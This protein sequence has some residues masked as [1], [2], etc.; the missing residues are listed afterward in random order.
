MPVTLSLNC[1]QNSQSIA[2]N[3]SNVTVTAVAAWTGGSWN[4]LGQCTGSIT[5]NGSEYTF[6]GMSFNSS[7]T[8]SG[9]QTVMTKTVN[10]SHNADGSKSLPI[11]AKFDTRV[12]SGVIT[13]SKTVTLTTIPRKSSMTVAN[14]TLGTAQT[15]TITEAASSFTHTI[16]AKC[17]SASTV[18]VCTKSTSNSISFTPPLSWASQNKTGTT[19]S[20]TYTLTTYSGNTNVGSETYTKTCSIPASVK[21]SCTV[22]V[23]DPTGYATA[24]G[25]YIKGLSKFRVT[26]TPTL[27]HSSPI[28]AYSASANGN[29]YNEASFTT[30]VLKSH[31]TLKV[32][33]TVTDQRNRTSAAA[34]TS[35]T[36]LDYS[37]PSIPTL[38]A[39]RCNEDGSA[40]DRG[41][42]IKVTYAYTYSVL[43]GKNETISHL[44]YKKSTEAAYTEPNDFDGD[45]N[46]GGDGI[47]HKSGAYMLPADVDSSYDIMLEVNDDFYNVA[48]VI[49]GSTGFT[50]MHWNA[51][52]NSM[53]IGKVVEDEYLLDVGVDTHFDK[54]VTLA[55]GQSVQG[56]DTDGAVYS[57]L[58]P[59]TNSGNTT[60]GYGLYSAG[61]GA[62][63]IYGNA[64]SFYT[65]E[66]IFTNNND[67]V[68]NTA[69]NICA[70]APDGETVKQVFSGQSTNGNTI[71]GYDNY[72]MKDGNT[73]I[74]GH[75]INF[76]VSDIPTPSFY[77]PYRKAGDTI[78]LTLRTTGYVTSSKQKV[79][80]FIS[81]AAPILGSPKVSISSTN[82]GVV[83]R[84]NDKYTHGSGWV[85]NATVYAPPSK[86]TCDLSMFAG[87]MVTLEFSDTT[88]A[89]N[90]APVGIQ[91]PCSI[92][93]S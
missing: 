27:S 21:P 46:G 36:V 83:L 19:V 91:W 55:N 79:E 13:A 92:V 2:N 67:V 34:T 56:V 87:I 10:V 86:I 81:L 48:K 61:R 14:G 90:N 1:R 30:G 4:A 28:K 75:N 49:T 53:G 38:T 8:S 70:I 47:V 35:I 74:Y 85:N 37:K 69:A 44:K 58:I 23:S 71:V 12:S 64:V 20:V 60:L 9:S 41:D 29:G 84:Q 68:M 6:S 5:I 62:T 42:F 40:N 18:T 65:K 33:A 11:S 76:Y 52:G 45:S 24:Y 25:G 82:G 93:F 17:G 39:A 54:M 15:L 51:E 31:G 16:T 73:H 32:S 77:R 43:S 26:V 72:A 22:S 89:I 78:N 57:A 7:H 88:N 80:F 66:G 50:L 63:N 3:T 59:V